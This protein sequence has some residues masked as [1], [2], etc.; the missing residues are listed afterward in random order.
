MTVSVSTDDGLIAAVEMG[1][2]T[3]L[4]QNIDGYVYEAH[5][6]DLMAKIQCTILV[7]IILNDSY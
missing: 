5:F 7:S 2:S 6:Y 3:D 4:K 1:K